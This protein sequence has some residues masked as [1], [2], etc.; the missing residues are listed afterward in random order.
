MQSMTIH[1]GSAAFVAGF[2]SETCKLGGRVELADTCGRDGMSR[3]GCE[4]WC[5]GD[6]S[7]ESQRRAATWAARYDGDY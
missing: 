2:V 7:E 3:S 1:D 6:L 5:G 4:R